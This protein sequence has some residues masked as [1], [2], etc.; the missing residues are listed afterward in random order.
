MY[1]LGFLRDDN[2]HPILS[3]GVTPKLTVIEN[4]L[5]AAHACSNAKFYVLAFAATFFLRH[6]KE[7][8]ECAVIHLHGINILYFGIQAYIHLFP[9]PYLC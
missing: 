2:Q 5:P 8:A 7:N 6:S 9:L 1:D 4:S 3:F